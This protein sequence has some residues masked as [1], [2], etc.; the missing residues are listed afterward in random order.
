MKV[1]KILSNYYNDRP[2]YSR[3]VGRYWATDA[4]NIKKGYL[5]PELFF[6][7]KSI[8]MSGVRFI[9]TGQAY[10][11]MLTKIF[12][13][14]K[15]DVKCQEKRVM[16]INEEI[17]LVVKP[18]YVFPDF[19]LE[20]K[21][22]FSMVKENTIPDRYKDQL[23]C[24]YFAFQKPVYLGVFST[25]FAINFISYKPSP[26]RWNNIQ[27]TLKTFHEEVKKLEKER[28]NVGDVNEENKN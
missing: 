8:D 27:K 4:S 23:E 5:T 6:E 10:E 26:R 2:K 16:K 21:Y 9:T 19:V 14:Q 20:T 28:K 24:E 18:D 1:D 25:P 13:E 7:P 12:K 11:D 22:P 3:T 15:V 17:D